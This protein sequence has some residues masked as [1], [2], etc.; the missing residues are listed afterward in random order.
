MN[1][2][3]STVLL[4]WFLYNLVG[5][6]AVIAIAFFGGFFGAMLGLPDLVGMFI[7][8]TGVSVSNF[9]IYKWSVKQ[10][11]NAD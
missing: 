9:F 1:M 11:I 10:I 4:W 5:T 6:L 8:I 2:K 3:N 7:G